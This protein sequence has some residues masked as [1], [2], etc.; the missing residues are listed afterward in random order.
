MGF[1]SL[2]PSR[3]GSLNDET[4]KKRKHRSNRLSRKSSNTSYTKKLAKPKGFKRKTKE[5][6]HDYISSSCRII[7][8]SDTVH[9]QEIDPLRSLTDHPEELYYQQKEYDIMHATAVQVVDYVKAQKYQEQQQ[10]YVQ[11][12]GQKRQ[13]QQ[14]RKKKIC[15]R[16]LE[17]MIEGPS[18]TQF[19]ARNCVMVQQESQHGDGS[20]NDED[21]AISYMRATRDSVEEARRRA[22][23]D[24]KEVEAY[25]AK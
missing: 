15:A 9:V 12:S 19:V 14:P 3:R 21:M 5:T 23:N 18:V 16:G 20:C 7:S 2:F 11:E 8:F 24:E 22:L 13:R 4:N 25:L 10:Q 6:Q 1:R 17:H